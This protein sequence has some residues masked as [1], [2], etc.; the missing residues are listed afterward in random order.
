MTCFELKGNN[1]TFIQYLVISVPKATLKIR[2]CC[3]ANP[4]LAAR[5]T[6]GFPA[7]LSGLS[8][9]CSSLYRESCNTPGSK[10]LQRKV[11]CALL[12]CVCV[13]ARAPRV[14]LARTGFGDKDGS[15]S[16]LI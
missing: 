4:Q 5:G 7:L 14:A 12:V 1:S 3:P 9:F 2:N 15:V 11:P 6:L 10:G 13:C 16:I 8:V